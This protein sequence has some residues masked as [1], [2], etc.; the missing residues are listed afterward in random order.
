MNELETNEKQPKPIGDLILRVMPEKNHQNIYGDIG[1]AWVIKQMEIAT[2]MLVAEYNP[3]KIATVAI[4]QM[5]FI[6]PIRIGEL[7]DVYAQ[8]TKKGKSSIHINLEIWRRVKS[9]KKYNKVTDGTFVVV[10]L[11]ASGR[12]KADNFISTS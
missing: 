8:I 4:S 1:A 6:S 7:I 3:E 10:I 12:I 9:A 5:D 11:N 2:Q